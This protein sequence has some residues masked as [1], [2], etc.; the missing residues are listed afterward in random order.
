MNSGATLR[1]FSKKPEKVR[2]TST[3]FAL[4]LLAIRRQFR[5]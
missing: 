1:G 3:L 2:I 4:F 5:R